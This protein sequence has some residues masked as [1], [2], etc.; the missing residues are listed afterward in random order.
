MH[1]RPPRTRLFPLPA[2]RPSAAPS[3]PRALGHVLAL[4]ALLGLSSLPAGRMS[5]AGEDNA[6]GTVGLHADEIG[7]NRLGEE[8]GVKGRTL[9]KAWL[10]NIKISD[11]LRLALSKVGTSPAKAKGKLGDERTSK[12]LEQLT[13][14]YRHGSREQT[15]M[16]EAIVESAYRQVAEGQ[17]SSPES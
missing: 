9:Y 16:L 17:S 1:P 13:F 3:R 6:A 8:V 11:R 5:A 2:G 4:L 7:F 10:G 12:C 15:Q 14:I